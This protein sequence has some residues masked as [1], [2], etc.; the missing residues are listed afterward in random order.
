MMNIGDIQYVS[1]QVNIYIGLFILILGIIGDILNIFVFANVK[2]AFAR[3]PCTIYLLVTA[4]IDLLCLSIGLQTKIL[5]SG[6]TID[7]TTSSIGFCK[8]R[9]FFTFTAPLIS[10]SFTCLATIVQ[11]FNTSRHLHFR[12][13]VNL[14]LIRWSL[15]FNTFFWICYGLPYI[16]LYSIYISTTTNMPTCTTVNTIMSQYTVWMTYNVLIFIIPILILSVFGYLTYRN[17]VS[18]NSIVHNQMNVTGQRIQRQLTVVSDV[19]HIS[20]HFFLYLFPL[21]YLRSY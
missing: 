7:P 4:V 19:Y 15:L 8:F 2:T 18:S 1:K 10:N 13:K 9:S 11:F 6:F 14:R 12:Q 17:I 3:N 16:V 21:H 5:A 20:S